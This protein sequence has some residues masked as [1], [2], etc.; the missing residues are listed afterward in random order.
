MTTFEIEIQAYFA[1]T[2]TPKTIR[3]LR[4]VLTVAIVIPKKPFICR[5]RT[6]NE[7]MEIN[8]RTIRQR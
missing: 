1:H 3:S 6:K 5:R 7:P 2:F 8:E 4:C